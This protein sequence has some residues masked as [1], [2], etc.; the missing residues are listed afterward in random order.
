MPPAQR[1]F[2][3]PPCP[4][5][6][7]G[8]LTRSVLR[9]GDLKTCDKCGASEPSA[10]IELS[11]YHCDVDYCASCAGV[12]DDRPA[13]RLRQP[14]TPRRTRFAD[15]VEEPAEGDDEAS[16]RPSDDENAEGTA[17]G[18]AATPSPKRERTKSRGFRG[19]VSELSWDSPG[20]KPPPGTVET[21]EERKARK[22]EHDVWVAAVRNQ[23][24]L[25]VDVAMA[26]VGVEARIANRLLLKLCDELPGFIDQLR[27]L[28]FLQREHHVAKCEVA[29]MLERDVFRRALD[30]APAGDDPKARCQPHAQADHEP[31]RGVQEGGE[32]RRAPH[33]AVHLAL[34]HGRYARRR[35]GAR[36][37]PGGR[38]CAAR[39]ASRPCCPH[40]D[41]RGQRLDQR[42]RRARW[43]RRAQWRSLPRRARRRRVGALGAVSGQAPGGSS[44]L[45]EKARR[46]QPARPS[47]S[48]SIAYVHSSHGR[49][50]NAIMYVYTCCIATRH[51]RT[52]RPFTCAR[53]TILATRRAIAPWWARSHSHSPPPGSQ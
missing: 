35:C 46:K 45:S 27:T 30:H 28:G 29:D 14:A 25:A 22:L 32:A 24:N 18:T 41:A 15:E 31:A 36:R 50:S 33:S 47:R 4:N 6:C 21:P 44:P 2:A 34:P 42:Q 53:S 3:A 7:G 40:D 19:R 52:I 23:T 16:D 9:N 43:Q 8:E 39:P 13:T 48:Y 5:R 11:C 20:A 12:R 1:T 51:V 49:L 26:R 10:V 17:E 38:D 37:R